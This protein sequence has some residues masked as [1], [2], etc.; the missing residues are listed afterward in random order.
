MALSL[1][2]LKLFPNDAPLLRQFWIVV[3]F[4]K[5]EVDDLSDPILNDGLK[6]IVV[7]ARL[8]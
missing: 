6:Q 3:V 4:E 8:R 2:P 5:F 7:Q 1:L